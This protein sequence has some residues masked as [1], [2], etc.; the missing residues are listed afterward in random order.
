[1]AQAN[2]NSQ[3]ALAL[4]RFA[5]PTADPVRLFAGL[6]A[7]V[8]PRRADDADEARGRFHLLLATLEAEPNTRR[9]V[10]AHFTALLASRR[11]TSFF[12][13]SGILPGTG[14]FTELW[15]L[16]S[17]RVLPELPDEQEFGDAMRQIFHRPRDW[18]WLDALDRAELL[19]FWRCI[20][21]GDGI[22]EAE[23]RQLVDDLLDAALLLAYRIGGLGIERELAPLAPEFRDFAARFLAV[24]RETQRFADG[25]RAHLDDPAAPVE[26]ERQLVVI[27][28]QCREVLKRAH[29]VART[30]GTSTHLTHL[31]IRAGQSLDRLDA[32]VNLLG[33]RFRPDSREAAITGWAAIAHDTIQAENRRDSVRAHVAGGLG[34]LALR[35]T[36]NAAQTGEHYIA[37]TRDEYWGMWRSAAGAGLIIAGMA[38]LKVFMGKVD[39]SLAGRALMYSLDYGIGF[40]VIYLLHLTVATKQPAMTAQTLVS[41]LGEVRRGRLAR[42]DAVADLVAGVVRTQLA[43]ILGNVTV[44]LPTAMLLSWGLG[45]ALGHPPIDAGKAAHLLEDLDP[46]GLALPHAAIAG[47]FL[48][49]SGVLSGY[50]DNKAR[51]ER[52]GARVARIG[53][54]RA[55]LGEGRAARF[56]GYLEAR[57]GGIMGNLLFGF[58]LGSTGTVGAILGWPLD[59]RHIAFA[60]ANLGFALV[61][62]DF[63][64]P[65]QTVATAAAGVLL[66][67]AV[68]LTVSFSLA[69]W[70]ALRARQVSIDGRQLR[71]L[72]GALWRRWRAAPLRFFGAPPRTAGGE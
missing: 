13:D 35:V 14:F 39:A 47:V 22:G 15:R 28:D 64:L 50:F 59:I 40:V 11:L 6:V 51:I 33:A 25:F 21:P 10:R 44:A 26:D 66:I 4:G 54:L 63:A 20:A 42:L 71:A 43:A 57:L 61:A 55:L 52:F 30:V 17:K 19:R 70:M 58:M 45:L 5:D 60:S 53:W 38:L 65:W 37:A 31:M 9:Q 41:Q 49:F 72:A 7:A 69:L 8:R 27:I 46:L 3:L 1:M 67:G 36:D 23:R 34:L 18:E 32:V 68:N 48:F 16:I 62:F 24:A 12:A 29:R 2:N 56:G